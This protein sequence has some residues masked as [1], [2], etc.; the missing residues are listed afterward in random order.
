M[1]KIKRDINHQDVKSEW[2]IFNFTNLQVVDRVNEAQLQVGENSLISF[3]VSNAVLWTNT[4]NWNSYRRV[5][6]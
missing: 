6:P 5:W 4:N 1:L 3:R 2:Q